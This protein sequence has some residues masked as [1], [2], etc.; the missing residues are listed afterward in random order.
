MIVTYL[1]LMESSI[2]QSLK[3]SFE[4]EK[5]IPSPG[6]TNVG[7]TAAAST[8]V[9]STSK[10]NK[11]ATE[12]GQQLQAICTCASTDELY[13]KLHALTSFLNQLNW[14]DKVYSSH[15]TTRLSKMASEKIIDAVKRTMTAFLNLMMKGK[16]LTGGVALRFSS[17]TD[18][19]VP[20]SNRTF[21]ENL[22]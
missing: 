21:L 7:T 3:K 20:V 11:S 17:P 16:G 5:W 18:Y 14:P 22:I 12:T 13:W 8:T 2:D 1:D 10:T 19:L 15:L 4:K 9:G 6:Q